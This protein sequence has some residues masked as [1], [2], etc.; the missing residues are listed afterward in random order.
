MHMINGSQ[1]LLQT[2][3]I[4]TFQGRENTESVK[5]NRVINTIIQRSEIHNHTNSISGHKQN[6]QDINKQ[7]KRL[8]LVLEPKPV[9][10]KMV[11][12]SIHFILYCL[13]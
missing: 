6:D 9:S 10:H 7:L 13:H 1:R 11:A 4:G 8:V 2:K 5:M 12:S 3:H